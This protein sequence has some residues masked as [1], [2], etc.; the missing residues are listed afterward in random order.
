[1]ECGSSNVRAGCGQGELLLIFLYNKHAVV[2]DPSR[3]ILVCKRRL[4]F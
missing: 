3:Q 4:L 2:S 1:M